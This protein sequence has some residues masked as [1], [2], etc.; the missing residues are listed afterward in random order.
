MSN[1]D[2]TMLLASCHDYVILLDAIGNYES[3][4]YVF[5]ITNCRRQKNLNKQGQV[6]MHRTV[7]TLATR[8]DSCED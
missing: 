2:S 8:V 6:V 7:S 5:G 1:D 3:N 4:G